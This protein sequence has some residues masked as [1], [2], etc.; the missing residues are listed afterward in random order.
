MKHLLKERPKILYRG[1]SRYQNIMLLEAKDVRL[2][3]DRQLQFSSLDER[4]YHEAL[5][6]PAM[7]MTPYRSHVLILG[8]GD[9][10]AVREVL[11]YK[12]VKSIDLVE[13]DPRM[14]QIAK[15]KPV[16]VLNGRS[17]FDKR[18][19]IHLTDARK[20]ISASRKTGSKRYNVI[21]MDFPDPSDQAL[22]KL[23]TREF[24]GR[25]VKLLAPGGKL[26][27]QSNSTEDKPSVY[28]S[29]YHTLRSLKMHTKSYAV[30]VPSFG[31]WG[32]Q[33]ASAAYFN[34]S[35]FKPIVPNRTLPR[36]FSSLFKLPKELLLERNRV[37][38]NSLKK[39][40]LFKYWHRDQNS[41]L[42][43]L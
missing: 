2:Y 32:F 28:W 5:V 19:K 16:S 3:L 38:P 27:I 14:I 43:H 18:V 29:I 30:Y 4:I 9:G 10:F 11:K 24:L 41:D 20:F 23:Y 37:K 7:S 25:I 13:L 12:D 42:S 1:K 40:R 26:V 21:I 8:G 15:K 36:N 39:L 31:D 35:K 17:L 34:P 33:L 22:S 6:H